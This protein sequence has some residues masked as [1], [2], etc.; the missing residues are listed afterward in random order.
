L[1]SNKASGRW[2]QQNALKLGS[3]YFNIPAA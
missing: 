1:I 2:L 3:L